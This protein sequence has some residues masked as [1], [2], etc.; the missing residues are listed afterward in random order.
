MADDQVF[1]GAVFTNTDASPILPNDILIRDL[2]LDNGVKR[3]TTIASNLVV[4]VAL[5]GANPGHQVSVATIMGQ[6]VTMRIL[7]GAAVARGDRLVSD[8]TAGLVRVD[9]AAPIGQI[10][11]VATRAKIAGGGTEI[12]GILVA[13]GAGVSGSNQ[14]LA[15]TYGFGLLAAD[16]TL[17]LTDAAG[18]GLVI[19]GT[20]GGFT[21]TNVLA[22]QSLGGDLVVSRTT[23]FV[24]INQTV[25]ARELHATGLT[26]GLRLEA[27]DGSAP[28]VVDI[29]NDGLLLEF[30]HATD[31]VALGYFDL[32]TKAFYANGGL[33][34]SLNGVASVPNTITIPTDAT[35]V[36]GPTNTARLRYNDGTGRLEVSLDGAAYASL[37]TGTNTF[38]GSI[39]ADQLAVGSGAN[40]LSGSAN[41]TWDGDDLSLIHG[42]GVVGGFIAQG[43][44]TLARSRYRLTTSDA[45]GN[46]ELRV[47][48][49]TVAGTNLGYPAAGQVSLEASPDVASAFT[50]ATLTDAPIVLAVN[51]AVEAVLDTDVL[52]LPGGRMEFSAGSAL[53]NSPASTG[54]IRYNESTNKLQYSVNGSGWVDFA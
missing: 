40:A 35:A 12:E 30:R 15:Q 23:G 41:L 18:G 6:R 29:E 3:T 52:A 34:P 16:Q 20:N 10:M 5:S 31:V 39:A 26:P 17:T 37:A 11:A 46:A 38:S 28:V 24:G 14:T 4:G 25:P 32:A 50:I 43:G 13:G 21:G 42:A 53:P 8:D 22:V 47:N 48:G 54:S 51:G 1:L 2:T 27:D 19:D 45:S 7:N 9:N 36:V 44:D 33:V 49:S